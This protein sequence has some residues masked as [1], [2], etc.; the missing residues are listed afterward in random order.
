MAKNKV[1][2]WS[3]TA[4]NNTDI[5]N[6]DIAEGCAPSG[7]NNGIREMMAQ[8]KDM[9]SGTDG[10]N[11]TVGGNLTV[12]GTT[13]L[14]SVSLTGNTT[15][16]D[17]SGDTLT[18]NGIAISTPNGLNFDTNT[19]VIDASNNR[20]GI[21]KA[22]PTT[23][24]DVTGTVTATA[25]AGALTGNVTG[26]LTGNVSGTLTGTI[27]SSTTGT[28]QTAGDNSTKVATTAYVKTATDNLGLGT[29]STQ[30]SNNVSITG[31]TITGSYGLTSANVTTVTAANIAGAIAPSTLGN[32]LTSNGT[33][34]VSS[35]PKSFGV[36]NVGTTVASG[37]TGS[38]TIPTNALMVM[39]TNYS[40]MS[41]NS[42]SQIS[43]NIKNSSGTTLYTYVLTGGNENNGGDGGSGM[44]SR[45]AWTVAIPST[46]AGGS[47]EF[48]R[49]GGSNSSWTVTVNQVLTY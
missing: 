42:G 14:S 2:E 36:T 3:S 18:I 25:F 21:A 27:A 26:N 43:V 44:S 29:I 6:I 7:I 9:Q 8:I 34:W 11:F 17:A 12:T 49:S 37:A 23:A 24:L 10:D 16:G 40:S 35:T 31:G 5:G 22:S 15:L 45:S 38:Y 39:G 4:S 48:F 19:F 33:A 13:T 46:A 1:S 32:V 20:V 41:G 47:L 30:N 28:T